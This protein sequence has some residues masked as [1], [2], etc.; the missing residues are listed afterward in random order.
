MTTTNS[1]SR[2]GLGFSSLNSEISRDELPLRGELPS[3]LSGSLLRTGPARWEVGQ[4]R[5]RHWFDG[6]AMLHRFTLAD[7]R[8]SYANK[9]LDSKAYRAARESNQI[10][11]GEFATDPC[12]SIFQRVQ[13]LFSPRK[14]TDNANVNIAQLGERFVSM[15]ESPIPVE[16]DQQTLEWAGVP[17][18]VPGQVTTAHP[19]YDRDTGDMLNYAVKMGRA[20]EYKFYRVNERSTDVLASV[21]VRQ[22][23]Y[24]HSFGITERWFVLAEFPLVVNPAAFVLS[25]KPFIENY[26]WRPERGTRFTLIDRQTGAI[27]GRFTGAAC[28]AF[29]HVNTYE[30]GNDVVVDLCAFDD[31]QVI[32]DLY[33]DRLRDA[34]REDVAGIQRAYLTRFRLSGNTVTKQRL[35]DAPFELPQIN[36][37]TRE[38]PHRYVWGT[39]I[40]HSWLDHIVKVDTIDGTTRK[41]HEPDRYP[42]EP[43]FVPR[44]QAEHEDD[45]VLLSVVLDAQRSNSFLLV[46]DAADLQEIARAEVP[47]H[48]PYGFHGQFSLR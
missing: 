26:R 19:H 35:S 43:V 45:G 6:M 8:V 17:Y 23:A 34:L 33:L 5:M 38:Q 20:T 37:V 25:G 36:E 24:M 3:W 14:G 22:P 42:G 10:E 46:L 40:G 13:T 48:I 18:R 21:P 7:G 12:R 32:Q 28:F 15:T 11:Y 16:F 44:P 2:A 9:F 41:W 1:K 4:S 30:D 39:G 29:H 27:G 47:H 31:S